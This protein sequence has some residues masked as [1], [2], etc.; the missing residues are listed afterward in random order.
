MKPPGSRAGRWLCG[1]A[2]VSTAGHT[3]GNHPAGWSGCWWNFTVGSVIFQLPV[4]Q[5]GEVREYQPCAVAATA[6]ATAAAGE[7]LVLWKVPPLLMLLTNSS[8]RRQMT[9]F[10]GAVLG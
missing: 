3:E 1:A 10:H 9:P 4:L 6:A 8:S 5:R 7:G 2:A